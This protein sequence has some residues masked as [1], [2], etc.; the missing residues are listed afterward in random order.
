MALSTE[1]T[2]ICCSPTTALSDLLTFT[3]PDSWVTEKLPFPIGKVKNYFW[4]A[5]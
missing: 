4:L 5:G 3:G 1:T 2:A